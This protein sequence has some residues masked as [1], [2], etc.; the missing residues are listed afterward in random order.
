VIS[1]VIGQDYFDCKG[2][3]EPANWQV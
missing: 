1:G 3:M 2:S